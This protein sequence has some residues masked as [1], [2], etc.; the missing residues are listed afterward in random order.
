MESVSAQLVAASEDLIQQMIAHP[1]LRE[2]ADG[3]VPDE[4][5]SRYLVQD[6]LWLME[7]QRTLGILCARAPMEVTRIFHDALLNLHGEIELFEEMAVR[8]GL[9]LSDGRM[10]L[11]CHAHTNFLMATAG[12]KTFAEGLAAIYGASLSY[13]R[14]WGW[15]RQNRKGPGRWQEFIDLYTGEGYDAWV[16]R[17][18]GMVDNLPSSSPLALIGRMKE[19]FRLTVRYEIYFWDAVYRNQDW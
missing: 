17:L 1:F 9:K 14:S 4:T 8:A 10:I 11:A 19:S 12:Y 5:F 6:Y 13:S 3:T 16:G 18:A 2:T 15:V 7:Y